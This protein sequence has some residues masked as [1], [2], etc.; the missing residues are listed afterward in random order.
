[1]RKTKKSIETET[2][3]GTAIVGTIAVICTV[4]F[5]VMLF[6][7]PY[8][9]KSHHKS[10]QSSFQMENK[11]EFAKNETE[12]EG[13]SIKE[14]VLLNSDT[15]INQSEISVGPIIE[16]GYFF[17]TKPNTVVLP[18][19]WIPE[20][21]Y[22]HP[23]KCKVKFN[24]SLISIKKD[25]VWQWDMAYMDHKF[26]IYSLDNSSEIVSCDY[27]VDIYSS[28]PVVQS[29][30]ATF[31]EH[32]KN[33]HRRRLVNR[34]SFGYAGVYF[35]K[36]IHPSGVCD[37][38]KPMHD[39]M[40]ELKKKGYNVTTTEEAEKLD[41]AKRGQFWKEYEQERS[42]AEKRRAEQKKE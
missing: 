35:L 17:V 1:M 24:S 40:A 15:D 26:A 39:P 33:L 32:M 11:I 38:T 41:R 5:V 28:D 34:N 3:P 19:Y 8:D 30:S 9:E 12:F 22:L 4:A 13:E 7:C 14:G 29:K 16:E 31:E 36:C 18:A 42:E 23:G 21:K 37:F 2:I 25:K 10:N 20:T 27:H 6:F